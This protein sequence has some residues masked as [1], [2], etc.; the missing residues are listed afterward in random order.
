MGQGGTRLTAAVANMTR[1]PGV[2]RLRRSVII[3]GHFYQPP[4]EDPWTDLVPLQP[5]AAPD[6]D[7][8]A[9]IERQCYGPISQARLVG[10]DGERTVNA[11]EHMSFNFGP[12]LLVWL[13]RHAPETY[14]RVLE[15][16]AR[17]LDRCGHGNAIAQAYHHSILPLATQRDKRTE[18][19]WG[20]DAFSSRFGRAPEGMWLPETAVDAETLDVVADQG[21]RFVILAPHQVDPLPSGGMPGR[22]RTAGGAHIALFAYDGA[23][24]HDAAFGE[25]TKDGAR[26]AERLATWGS[27][28]TKLVMVATDGETYGH[29]HVFAEMGLVAALDHLERNPD[30]V[31]ENPGAFLDR[32]PAAVEVD[33][34]APTSWS[35]GHGVERWRSDCGCRLDPASETRQAWRQPLRSTLERLAEQLHAIFE[36]EAGPWL[37]DPW[38]ARDEYG[39]VVDRG[40]PEMIS[41]WLTG[42]L[43]QPASPQQRSR[44][45]ELMEMERDTLRMFT[46]CAWFFDDIDRL[47]PRQVLAYA[48]RA[49]G[50][51][52]A[53]ARLEPAFLAGLH[54]APSNNPRVG[55]GARVF[56]TL[57]KGAAGP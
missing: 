18:V 21:I 36:E 20:V 28:D 23:L 19:R 32:H 57:R 40:D 4:R 3:H 1:G 7:W 25:A 33:I 53:R 46:S 13:E 49:M 27:R 16:D 9:R 54:A 41:E 55:H 43:S 45:L 10:S 31:L 22:Y 17:S 2:R 50:L 48:A 5:S 51:S 44:L 6:H 24:S 30:V 11:L 42:H 14:R 39:L 8:N 56:Q 35:C 52:G 15:A 34:V 26:W 47:E 38:Q 12:T 29:H 37:N